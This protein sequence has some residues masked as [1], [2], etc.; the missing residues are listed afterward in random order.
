MRL[1]QATCLASAAGGAIA[2]SVSCYSYGLVW[3][4]GGFLLGGLGGLL[5]FLLIT[6]FC[7]FLAHITGTK[8]A[9]PEK[10]GVQHAVVGI[11][12]GITVLSPFLSI[13][14]AIGIM[15]ILRNLFY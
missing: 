11:T 7:T 14:A 6:C 1:F 12:L 4:L 5:S 8:G 13:A 2:G 15:S 9:G 3:M 10:N